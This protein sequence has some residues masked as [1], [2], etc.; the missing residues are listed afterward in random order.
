MWRAG[1]GCEEL[2]CALQLCAVGVGH[3]FVRMFS[4][5]SGMFSEL[6]VKNEMRNTHAH[7]SHTLDF[8][9]WGFL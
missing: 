4:I 3:L 9:T 5:F 8:A 2:L 7:P 1:A 6:L